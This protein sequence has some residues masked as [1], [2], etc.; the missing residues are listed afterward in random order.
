[1]S[2]PAPYSIK[3]NSTAR[4]AML[5]GR[6]TTAVPAVTAVL[7]NLSTIPVYK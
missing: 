5:S 7:V 6:Q 1:M 2:L 4:L 3:A